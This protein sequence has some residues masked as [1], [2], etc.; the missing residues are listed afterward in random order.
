MIKQWMDRI[1]LM[2][3]HQRGLAPFGCVV[4]NKKDLLTDPDNNPLTQAA[5]QK[6][7][8]YGF[9]YFEC[10]TISDYEYDEVEA[11]LGPFQ[12]MADM[13]ANKYLQRQ[14]E[15]PPYANLQ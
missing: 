15:L 1:D 12:F 5:T 6:A 14:M 9:N 10:S 7:G 13:Y 11:I 8:E 2:G 3:M 4:G